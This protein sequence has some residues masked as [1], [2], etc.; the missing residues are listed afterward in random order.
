[1]TR[2]RPVTERTGDADVPEEQPGVQ[3]QKRQ[4]SQPM[5]EGWP[6]GTTLHPRVMEA[7]ERAYRNGAGSGP[8]PWRHSRENAPNGR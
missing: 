8:F 1:M 2:T 6:D 7:A 5:W 4:Q 3:D